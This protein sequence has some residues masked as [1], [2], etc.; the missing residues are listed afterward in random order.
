MGVCSTAAWLGHSHAPWPFFHLTATVR[1]TI[2]AATWPCCQSPH[3]MCSRSASRRDEQE[4]ERDRE[5]Q[6]VKAPFLP[7]QFR[8]LMWKVLQTVY[9]LRLQTEEGKQDSFALQVLVSG[10]P[11]LPA[12]NLLPLV[13]FFFPHR[14][15]TQA[16]RRCFIAVPFELM[17]H[18][19]GGRGALQ[20][21][22]RHA[23]YAANA[24]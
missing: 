6:Q 13:N 18:E 14:S 7:L 23:H 1:A 21:S 12:E 17:P 20:I 22:A 11:F 19:G 16:T 15:W 10:H 24:C 4:G 5:R 9:I 3:A 2:V 8:H